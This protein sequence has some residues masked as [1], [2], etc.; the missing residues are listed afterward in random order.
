MSAD[1]VER[2]LVEAR[3]SLAA[4]RDAGRGLTSLPPGR[5]PEIEMTMAM[6]RGSIIRA[7]E[8]LDVYAMVRRDA[9]RRDRARRQ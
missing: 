4:L 7:I 3:R 2:E 8:L 1:A 5:I 6:V 9:I